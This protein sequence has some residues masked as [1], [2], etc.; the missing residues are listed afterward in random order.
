MGVFGFQE[1]D[2]R[3]ECQAGLNFSNTDVMMVLDTT[4]SMRQTNP[5]DTLPKIDALKNTIALFYSQLMASRRGESRIRFGFVPYSANVNV[6]GL[7]KSDWVVDRWSYQS[8]QANGGG[9][10]VYRPVEHDLS[11]LKGA[12]GA[13][14]L[15]T[16]S[17][18]ANVGGTALAP[19]SLTAPF[20]GC[21]E[22]RSTYEI[23]DYGNVDLNRALDLD[24][25]RVPDDNPNTR[26][27]PQFPGLVFDRA[28]RW[29][30]S[31]A[32]ETRAV[33]TAAEYIAVGRGGF[34]AC[35]APARKLDEMTVSELEAYLATLV[36][37]GSTYHDIGMIWGGRLLSPTGLFAA[38]NADV[39]RTLSTSRNLVFLTDGETAPLDLVYS[40]YG[41]EPVDGRRWDTS[42]TLSLRDTVEAR[43]AFACNEVKKRNIAVW[44]VAFGTA[45]NPVMTECAGPGHYFTADNA[46][47]LNAAF[48]KIAEGI[49]D[50]R[51]VR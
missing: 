50:L 48:A 39:S 13:D 44:F 21:I 6:G 26:W 2:V 25:D 20:T 36:A 4:G 9:Q 23:T 18:V 28:I 35:P 38:E 12:S 10:W 11:F 17:I 22:E 7:L 43:F 15:G 37:R 51:I 34:A 19:A 1:L 42:S 14:L 31:G 45:A 32:W 3:A 47:E 49:G 41:V 8:R 29:D 27:R 5:G 40:S 24:I 46:A 30:G 33:N 16:G